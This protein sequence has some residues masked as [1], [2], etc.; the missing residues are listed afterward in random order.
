MTMI[1]AIPVD[2]DYDEES[3]WDMLMRDLR[4]DVHLMPSWI[5]AKPRCEVYRG[6]DAWVYRFDVD[7]PLRSEL[8]SS[9]Y[10]NCPYLV[11]EEA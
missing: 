11:I 4:D 7:E 1:I 6:I 5:D 2:P 9:A 10:A 3:S 8:L